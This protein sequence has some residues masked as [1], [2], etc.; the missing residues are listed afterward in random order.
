MACNVFK[1]YVSHIHAP[2]SKS[3][4][5]IEILALY[6]GHTWSRMTNDILL[7]S[8]WFYQHNC[9]FIN[10]GDKR[11]SEQRVSPCFYI[12][13]MQYKHLFGSNFRHCS[14]SLNLT[15]RFRLEFRLVIAYRLSF[16]DLKN[17]TRF[18]FPDTGYLSQMVQE[19]ISGIVC[20]N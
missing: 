14:S 16:R 1:V 4:S 18:L 8:I 15:Q 9:V 20:L 10:A 2:R 19:F 5:H 11:K 13:A 6:A 3:D 12:Q 17:H 7:S